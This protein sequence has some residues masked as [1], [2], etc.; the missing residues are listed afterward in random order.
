MT[1]KSALRLL[2]LFLLLPA[3]WG[4]VDDPIP[5]TAEEEAWLAEGHRVRVRVSDWPPFQFCDGTFEGIS[6]DYIKKIFDR[7][8]IEYT[9]VSGYDVPWVMALESIAEHEVIDLILTAKITESRKSDMLFTEEYLF[10]PW[11][12]YTRVDYPFIR[13]VEDLRGKTISVPEGFVIADLIREN[14]P[15]ITLKVIEGPSVSEKCLR[16]VAEGLVDAHIGNLTVGSYII[17][18]QGFTNVKVAAPTPFG[19]HDQAM[20]VRNDWP[21]LVGIINKTLD[22]FSPEEVGAIQN[23]WL[24]VRYEHGVSAGDILKWVLLVSLFFLTILILSLLWNRKLQQEI[25]ARKSAEELL[26]SSEK[27]FRSLSEATFEGVIL[28]VRGKIIDGNRAAAEM[29]GYTGEELIGME[30]MDL[31]SPQERE[32]QRALLTD[33]PG[34]YEVTGFRK[35][36]TLFPTEARE[37]TAL[38]GEKQVNV[39]AIRDLTEKRK[40]EEQIRLLHR[41]LPIC[42]QCGQ[43]RDD[44]GHWSQL[45]DFVRKNSNADFSHSLCPSCAKAL[46]PR[47]DLEGD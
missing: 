8:G 4:G 37:K 26:Q 41:I 24:S 16:E 21:E 25:G 44:R 40:T 18:N 9:F 10:L 17:M 19:S 7:H 36:G 34:S 23:R 12:I 14:Y 15:E 35:D 42:S 38:Y 5:L 11:V 47:Y 20:A 1:G 13:G 6:V 2:F 39:I 33:N 46:Y 27:R 43:V 22:S 32:R 30:A 29:F 28:V 31:V 3:L 45:E